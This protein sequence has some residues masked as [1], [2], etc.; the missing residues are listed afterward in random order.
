MLHSKLP[1][2]KTVTAL[3]GCARTATNSVA[4]RHLLPIGAVLLTRSLGA[5]SQQAPSSDVRTLN[6][7]VIKGQAKAP[8]AKDAVRATSTSIGKGNQ[9]LRDIPQSITVV[10]EKLLDERNLNPVAY[11]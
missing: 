5:Y 9:Q 6:P 2:Q 7:V 4:N 10:T 1:T 3:T 8:E 11:A